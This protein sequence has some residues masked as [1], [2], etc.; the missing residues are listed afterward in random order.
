MVAKISDVAEVQEKKRRP[1]K[2]ST[3]LISASRLE[4]LIEPAAS[5]FQI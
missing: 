3:A 5:M 4:H 1:K 2:K